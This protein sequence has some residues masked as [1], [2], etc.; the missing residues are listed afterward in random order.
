M[1]PPILLLLA[2][3]LTGCGDQLAK[4][5]AFLNQFVGRP[6]QDLVQQLGVPART[7]ET[8]GAKYLAY[9]D[10]RIDIIP[11]LPPFAAGPWWV[12][13]DYGGGFPPQVVTL[14]CET[15]F[16]IAGGTVKSY[17]LHGNACG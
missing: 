15:T 10:S 4:R 11:P 2:V 16:A 3:I 1:R 13:G 14:V 9:D 8:G 5:E 12:Y 6:E 7:Y 17:T